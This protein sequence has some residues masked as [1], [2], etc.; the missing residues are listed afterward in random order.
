MREFQIY[1]GHDEQ[2]NILLTG[3]KLN[4]KIQNEKKIN[5]LVGIRNST[6]LDLNTS[7]HII[8]ITLTKHGIDENNSERNWV[9][10]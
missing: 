1:D 8:C 10:S 3:N 7:I 5:M 4:S 9:K 2:R 6:F